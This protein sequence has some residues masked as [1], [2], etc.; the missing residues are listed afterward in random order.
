MKLWLEKAGILTKH[1]GINEDRL[2]E[3]LGIG[4]ETLS[5]SYGL[6]EQQRDFLRALA[7]MPPPPPYSSVDVAKKAIDLYGTKFDMAFIP[8]EVLYPLQEK[9]LITLQRGTKEK[10]RGSKPF[11]V[12]P[13]EKFKKEILGP[14]L[15]DLVGKLDPTLKNLTQ[16][17]LKE[18]LDDLESADKNKKGVALEALALN[19]MSQLGLKFL[20][21]RVR[22]VDTGGAEVD[23]L[24]ES[25]R[26]VY[27][28]WQVQC[29]N[30]RKVGIED[31]VREVGLQPLLKSN[32][33]VFI[34]TGSFAKQ[35]KKFAE[36]IMRHTNLVIV[37]IEGK[38]IKAIAKNPSQIFKV[39]HKNSEWARSLKGAFQE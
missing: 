24:F 38:D 22:A 4:Y 9:G 5:V 29:K 8:K 33:I 31:I 6:T 25:P 32:V 39:M 11:K 18:I 27:S 37:L 26:L 28:R 19:I 20:G 16:R 3:I 14:I 30:T 35:A 2:K 7:T 36:K 12:F 21:T 34:T 13:T 10:G 1:Y 23:L 15:D 17:P